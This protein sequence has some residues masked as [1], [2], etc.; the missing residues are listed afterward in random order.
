VADQKLR[1]LTM[2]ARM[3]AYCTLLILT[4]MIALASASGWSQTETEIVQMP[5]FPVFIDVPDHYVDT[6]QDGYSAV[7]NIYGAVLADLDGDGDQEVVFS[8]DYCGWPGNGCQDGGIWAWDHRGELLPGFPVS[9]GAAAVLTPSIGD[10]DCDGT[11][12]IVQITIDDSGHASILAVD[13]LGTIVPGFPIPVSVPGHEQFG[14]ASFYG[15]AT[16]YDL[17]LDGALEIIY[18]TSRRV[19]I[20]EADGRQ[21]DNGWPVDIARQT[22][23][24]DVVQGSTPA[25]A[26]MDGDGEAEVFVTGMKMLHMFELT[27]SR[28]VGWPV[29]LPNNNLVAHSATAVADLDGDTDLEVIVPVDPTDNETGDR[30]GHQVCVYIYHHDGTPFEGWPKHVGNDYRLQLQ[31]PPLVTDLEGDG[32]LEVLIAVGRPRDESGGHPGPVIYAWDASGARRPGFPVQTGVPVFSMTLLTAADVNGDGMMEIFADAGSFLYQ[33]AWESWDGRG[34]VVG[35][36]ANGH[37]L[38]GFPLR[39]EGDTAGNG[40]IIGDVDGDGDYELA[41]VGT[42]AGD[43]RNQT[44]INLLDLSGSYL[45]SDRDWRTY[46]SINERGGV[47][48]R[49]YRGW[50]VVHAGTRRGGGR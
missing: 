10:I 46:H 23:V 36:D 31:C 43:S 9:T 37:T 41:M 18:P 48:K 15:V 4:T 30:P 47:F 38:P 33:D 42:Y 50:R 12:E 11:Q 7:Y 49:S 8:G 2:E 45:A 44:A 20:Y 27:G 17:D 32:V 14:Q 5:G 1:L 34:Y 16:L 39:T 6:D 25:I 26:D 40:V 24:S 29:T 19:H 35:I 21:W 13:H 22:T 28:A 3:K